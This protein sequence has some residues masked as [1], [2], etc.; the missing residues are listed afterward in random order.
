MSDKIEPIPNDADDRLCVTGYR[1][2]EGLH[3]TFRSYGPNTA[4]KIEAHNQSRC[5]AL[6]GICYQEACD[7]L[8]NQKPV[9]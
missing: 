7:E 8:N 3:M 5:D 6:C 2:L 4:E 1:D 9:A